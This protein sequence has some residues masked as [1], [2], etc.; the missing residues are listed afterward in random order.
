M[1]LSKPHISRVRIG[2]RW[3]WGVWISRDA[4]LKRKT[5]PIQVSRDFA[6]A[7]QNAAFVGRMKA[8]RTDA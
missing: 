3:D 5:K 7:R 8:E 4:C 1:R 2:S 6:A